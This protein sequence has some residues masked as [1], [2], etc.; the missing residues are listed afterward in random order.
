MHII[1][2]I[3][4]S[5]SMDV[6]R[7][8]TLGSLNQFIR[9]QRK[10]SLPNDGWSGKLGER[11]P[12]NDTFTLVKFHEQI[13]YVVTQR[14]M[15]EAQELTEKDYAPNNCTALYDAIGDVCN[16]FSNEKEVILSIMTDGLENS[17]RE[18]NY[19]QVKKLLDTR[20]EQGW[21]ISYLSAGLTEQAQ[22]ENYAQGAQLGM[23]GS[24]NVFVGTDR[25]AQ[26]VAGAQNAFIGLT[27][28]GRHTSLQKAQ[29][30][31]E[32]ECEEAGIDLNA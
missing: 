32:E 27:R 18:F 2:L 17:S 14:K 10:L 19:E 29:T 21:E 4:E 16:R 9:T 20:K 30:T 25:F 3:D 24:C 26:N 5:G 8:D 31:G 12:R 1:L 11:D 28:M 13:N 15:A 6:I 23:Q 7:Q 22:R